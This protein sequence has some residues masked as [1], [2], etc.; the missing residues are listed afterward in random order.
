M[1]ILGIGSVASLA[2]DVIDKIFPDKTQAAAAKAALVQAQLAGSLREIDN[3]YQLAIEQVKAN[4]AEGATPGLHFRDGA[5][6]VCVV[7]FALMILKAPIEWGCVLASHPIT[8]P[9]VDTSTIMPMLLGLLG[10][11]GMHVYGQVKGV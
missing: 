2:S 7:G 3:Q 5:G 10:L 11:G 8:L 9:A 1:D 4:A 6:W